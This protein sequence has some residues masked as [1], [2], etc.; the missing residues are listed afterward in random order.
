MTMALV[1]HSSEMFIAPK[2]PCNPNPNPIKFHSFKPV[3]VGSSARGLKAFCQV[4]DCAVLELEQNLRLYGEFSGAVKLG[5]KEEEEEKQ[6]YY[7]NMGYAIRTLREDFPQIFFKE[8]S[9]D[10]YS[11]WIHGVL[12]SIGSTTGC[13]LDAYLDH[14]M[15]PPY[16]VAPLITGSTSDVRLLGEMK[17]PP[18][19]CGA[20]GRPKNILVAGTCVVH[21]FHA[22]SRLAMPPEEY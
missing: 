21:C 1:I 20:A 14:N 13:L 7:V 3:A 9:F 15:T 22:F 12:K 19:A 4:K 16:F 17:P 18:A 8:P 10:V 6:K 5:R 2:F 11:I